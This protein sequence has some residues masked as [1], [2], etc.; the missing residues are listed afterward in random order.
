MIVTELVIKNTKKTWLQEPCN[1]R[2]IG[3]NAAAVMVGSFTLFEET[4]KRKASRDDTYVHFIVSVLCCL[5]ILHPELVAGEVGLQF[6]RVTEKI[7][8]NQS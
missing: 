8:N 7:L 2:N 1:V 3:Y 6:W 5:G 4:E